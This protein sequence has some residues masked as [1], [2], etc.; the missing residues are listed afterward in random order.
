MFD[1]S[2]ISFANRTRVKDRRVNLSFQPTKA[3][4]FG[5]VTWLSFNGYGRPLNFRTF[6]HSLSIFS[7]GQDM[8]PGKRVTSFDSAYHL[9]GLSDSVL[10]YTEGVGRPIERKVHRML[11]GVARRLPPT[12]SIRRRLSPSATT[13]LAS[14]TSCSQE[15]RWRSLR[16][17]PVP[18]KPAAKVTAGGQ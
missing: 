3:L 9:T 5:S 8:D 2:P 1:G 14:T 17:L 4:E 12:G 15:A 6:L 7:N 13:G 16:R 18:M 11:S 10:L